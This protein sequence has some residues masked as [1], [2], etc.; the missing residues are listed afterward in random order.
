LNDPNNPGHN[1]WKTSL[2]KAGVIDLSIHGKGVNKNDSNSN[3]NTISSNYIDKTIELTENLSINGQPAKNTNIN[4][5]NKIES[6]NSF[7]INSA[8]NST[9]FFVANNTNNNNTGNYSTSGSVVFGQSV[10]SE[11]IST[12]NKTGENNMKNPI[13]INVNIDSIINQQMTSALWD[14]MNSAERQAYEKYYKIN[15]EM[16][17]LS[18]VKSKIDTGLRRTNEVVKEKGNDELN[19]KYNQMQKEN[20]EK[21]KDYRDAILKMKQEKRNASIKEVI[22]ILISN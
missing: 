10:F 21:L 18:G 12:A 5:N 8:N 4:N 7:G 19:K 6:S 22:K 13:D 2:N 14:S 9:G 11:T 16:P 17:N 3:N 15:H 1:V 20:Q